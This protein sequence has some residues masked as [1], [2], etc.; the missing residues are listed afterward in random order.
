M[1]NESTKKSKELLLTLIKQK[2]ETRLSKLERRNKMHLNI[3][4]ITTQTIK[5]IT[6]WSINANNQIKEKYKK[7]NTIKKEI[8]KPKK[9]ESRANTRKQSFRSN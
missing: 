6:D 5:D 4:N 1:N 7:N 8:T 3:M 9:I 2:L